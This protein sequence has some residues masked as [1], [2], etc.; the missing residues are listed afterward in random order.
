MEPAGNPYEDR[1]LVYMDILGWSSLIDQS[2]HNPVL[3]SLNSPRCRPVR[4]RAGP[5]SPPT[6]FTSGEM[7]SPSSRPAVAR[8]TCTS[9]DPSLIADPP[10]TEVSSSLNTAATSSSPTGRTLQSRLS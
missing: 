5:R 3:A 1:I 8:R 7:A 10:L 6:S 4:V 9:C 2:A